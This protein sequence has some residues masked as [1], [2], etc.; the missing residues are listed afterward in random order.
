MLWRRNNFLPDEGRGADQ[1]DELCE[2]RLTR[3]SFVAPDDLDCCQ[4]VK[5]EDE[6][7]ADAPGLGLPC[8]QMLNVAD[9]GVTKFA[10]CRRRGR[11]ARLRHRRGQSS[12]P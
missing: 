3:V 5:K 11:P 9:L 7:V 8:Q 6:L 1:R 4:R 10:G 2:P 12:V